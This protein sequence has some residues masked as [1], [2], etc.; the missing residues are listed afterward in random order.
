[1]D[2][3][4]QVYGFDK[5]INGYYG[6]CILRAIGDPVETMEDAEL[7]LLNI[8]NGKTEYNGTKDYTILPIYTHK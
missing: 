7:T 1:M 8:H 5:V 6:N 4:Y 3:K 2:K